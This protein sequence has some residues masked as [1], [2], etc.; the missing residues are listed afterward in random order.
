LSGL[1]GRTIDPT[2][3][4][5]TVVKGDV[6][7]AMRRGRAALTLRDSGVPS[8][9]VARSD[10]VGGASERPSEAL[11]SSFIDIPVSNV[12]KVIASRLSESK[13]Q[14]PHEY[15]TSGD[16]S[17]RGVEALRSALRDRNV[18]ASVND[19]VLYAVSRALRV[20]P[21]I[22][23]TWDSQEGRIVT[24]PTVDVAI[25]VSTASGLITPIV[26]EADSKSLTAIGDEVRDLVARA[27]SPR[28]LK[29]HEYTGGSFS[30]S[31]LGM[32]TVDAFSAILN[33]PQGAIM[34]VGR[35]RQGVSATATGDA[36]STSVVSVTV[37]SDA[38]VA[39]VHDVARFLSVF[40]D[41]LENPEG[42]EGF[43]KWKL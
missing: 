24:S 23:A 1:D 11:E 43:E 38:R 41:I 40:K 8:S 32:F 5:G 15:V 36:S 12:R 25:A 37:S 10:R 26:F 35:G 3:P 13:R 29:P 42:G 30:V 9:E 21:R 19:C 20:S 22:N 4:K 16:I 39:T 34:A 33:P 7:A 28:G 6:L 18:R 27:R 31:N 17:L 2:G 14:S